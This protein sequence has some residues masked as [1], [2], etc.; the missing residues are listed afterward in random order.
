MRRIIFP[1][2]IPSSSPRTGRGLRN[3]SIPR[4][5]CTFTPGAWRACSGYRFCPWF[6]S[7]GRS[8]NYFTDP[9]RAWAW[10][11]RQF[12][13]RR[14]WVCHF[15]SLRPLRYRQ[16]PPPCYYCCRCCPSPPWISPYIRA[17][18]AS[19]SPSLLASLIW[20]WW[21]WSPDRSPCWRW[22]G[23]HWCTLTPLWR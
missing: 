16:S 18:A 21:Y 2:D 10:K 4:S 19:Q 8:Q 22:G 14:R 17:W 20:P 5:F 15:L 9:G 13:Q 23:D 7:L 6:S 1:P 11:Y 3:H 12:F